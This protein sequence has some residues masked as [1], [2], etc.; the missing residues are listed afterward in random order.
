MAAVVREVVSL[1]R[2]GGEDGVEWSGD[3]ADVPVLALARGDELKEVLLNVLEN[4][5]HAQ[6]RRVT[7][8]VSARTSTGRI[9]RVIAVR[10]DGQGIASGRAAANLRAA[11]LD[12]H[13]RQRLGTG[14]QPPTRRGLGRRASP[15]KAR[16]GN[17]VTIALSR[18]GVRVYER[19]RRYLSVIPFSPPMS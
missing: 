12:A 3:G 16:R 11:F 4:A 2:M 9:A 14:D 10:D 19:R 6:A 8:R 18:D 5:R 13:E 17:T 7:C 15:S 1:E